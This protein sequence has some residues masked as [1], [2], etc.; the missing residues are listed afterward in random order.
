[1]NRVMFDSA[2]GQGRGTSLM[3]DHRDISLMSDSRGTLLMSGNTRETFSD[4][5][6]A[7]Y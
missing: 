3:S 7:G 5:V 1:M 6:R 2:V 4:T